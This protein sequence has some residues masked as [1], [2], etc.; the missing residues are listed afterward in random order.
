MVGKYRG[1]SHKPGRRFSQT[2]HFLTSVADSRWILSHH[3][4][5]WH[6]PTDVFETDESIVVKV[7]V[8]GMAEDD[9]K[10]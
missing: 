7:E 6:P 2:S 10:G 9:F 4:Q 1:R 8:A 5:V 3:G